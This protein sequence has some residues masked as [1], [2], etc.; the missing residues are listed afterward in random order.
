MNIVFKI[1]L[2]ASA[3]RPYKAQL[4]GKEGGNPSAIKKRGVDIIF[5]VKIA[6]MNAS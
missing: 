5:I 4:V 2:S 1:L 6:E 3:A